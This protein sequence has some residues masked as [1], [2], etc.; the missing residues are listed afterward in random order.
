MMFMNQLSKRHHI[1][2]LVGSIIDLF[3]DKIRC[4]GRTVTIEFILYT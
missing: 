2:L 3:L 4:W 1:K